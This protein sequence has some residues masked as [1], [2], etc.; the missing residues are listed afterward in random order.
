MR[1]ETAKHDF[2]MSQELNSAVN[3]KSIPS[4]FKHSWGSTLHC[5]VATILIATSVLLLISVGN[6]VFIWLLL[7]AGLIFLCSE[8]LAAA[9]P[10][11]IKQRSIANCV[12]AD[13]TWSMGRASNERASLSR[14]KSNMAFVIFLFVAPS[15]FGVWVFNKEVI[16]LGIGAEAISSINVDPNTWKNSLQDDEQRFNKWQ[17]STTLTSRLDTND[18][19]QFLW[20]SWPFFLLGVFIW[21]GVMVTMLSKYYLYSLR[22]LKESVYA[23]ASDYRWRDLSRQPMIDEHPKRRS[24]GQKSRRSRR[25]NTSATGTSSH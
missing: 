5:A 19:K 24:R 13:G 14:F 7:A 4:K 15:L 17:K 20:N 22:K 23:R 8:I 9:M 6:S 11:S 18:H 21:C 1:T 3:T 2:L 16:P 10:S 25:E 12:R